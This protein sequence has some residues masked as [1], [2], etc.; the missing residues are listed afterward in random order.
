MA[1]PRRTQQERSASTRARLVDAAFACL[2]DGGY[3]ATT[4]G[5]VQQRAGV[6]RGTLLHHFPTRTALMLGVL[7]DIA[8]RRLAV[9]AAAPSGSAGPADWD[10]LVDLVWDD[11]RSP[12]FSAALELWVAARTDAELR[13]ALV[14]VQERLF[15]T[16]HRSVTALVGD[17]D[18]RVPTLVQFSI[19]L[20]TGSRLAGL[21][22]ERAGTP[23]IVERWRRALPLLAAAPDLL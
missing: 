14:P 1:A 3:A 22:E 8:G 15:G 10:A 5:A 23:A 4:L 20:L 13:A 21:L 16:V 12:A 18:P 7:D 17:A 6:A 2:L 19:D 11:L 9:L